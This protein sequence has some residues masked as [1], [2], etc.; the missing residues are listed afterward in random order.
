MSI[1]IGVDPGA[2]GGIAVVC[3]YLDVPPVLHAMPKTERDIWDIVGS[4]DVQDRSDHVELTC[5]AV[6][7]KVGGFMPGSAGN[8]GS[9]MFKFGSSY[10]F[11][12]GCLTAAGIPFD[13]V[14]P[15]TWQKAL[16][17][18]ARSNGESKGQFKNRL[19][20]KAQQLFPQVNV[21]LATCDALLLAEYCRRIKS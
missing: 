6:I 19:K 2:S 17:V 10:G 7:E 18:I 15:R 4:S 9:A 21:T 13:E 16:G 11:L 1:F 3:D 20:Q 14:H 12:R 5:F 8:I